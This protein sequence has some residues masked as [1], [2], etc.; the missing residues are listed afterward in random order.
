ME[1]EGFEWLVV[2]DGTV[3]SVAIGTTAEVGE[4]AAGVSVESITPTSII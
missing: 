2:N 4:V 1:R 3:N